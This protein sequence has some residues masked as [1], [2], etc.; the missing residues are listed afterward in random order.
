MHYINAIYGK[1]ENFK[2]MMWFII[3]VVVVIFFI[4]RANKES[5]V[6]DETPFIHKYPVIVSG[7]N[8]YLYNGEAEFETKDLREHYLYKNSLSKKSYVQLIYRENTLYLKYYE[9]FMEIKTNY[10]FHYSGIKDINDEK[11]HFIA[12]D[13]SNRVKTEAKPTF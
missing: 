5:K 9:D 11:Q 13:F 7:I 1:C 6:L 10:S 2:N 3:I 4:A 12:Q 8:E